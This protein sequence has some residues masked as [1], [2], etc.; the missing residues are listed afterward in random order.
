MPSR[1]G[2]C[3]PPVG[4]NAASDAVRRSVAWFFGGGGYFRGCFGSCVDTDSTRVRF[5][6]GEGAEPE[7]SG[8]TTVGRRAAQTHPQQP[9]ERYRFQYPVVSAMKITVAVEPLQGQRQGD[10]KPVDQE[11]VGMVV[12]DVF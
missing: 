12:T 9:D 1:F 6:Q 7:S 4:L 10:N 3:V 5:A 8:S 11:A 2:S